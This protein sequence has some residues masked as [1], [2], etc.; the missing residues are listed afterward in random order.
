MLSMGLGADRWFKGYADKFWMND[1]F[2]SNFRVKLSSLPGMLT[3]PLK[4]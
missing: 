3:L 1:L 2:T 4:K